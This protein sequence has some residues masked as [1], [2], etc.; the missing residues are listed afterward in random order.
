MPHFTDDD[1]PFFIVIKLHTG[2]ELGYIPLLSSLHLNTVRIYC[3]NITLHS[4]M[5]ILQIIYVM[6][7][8]SSIY[9]RHEQL[10]V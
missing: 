2:K 10:Q 9:M 4:N 6:S 5:L 8:M 3:N 7:F 1:V